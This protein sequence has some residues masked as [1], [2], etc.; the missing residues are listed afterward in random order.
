MTSY[1]IAYI[2]LGSNLNN[3][4]AQID[5]AVLALRTS[6]AVMDVRCSSY[7]SS[8]AIGPGEQPDY[9][10]AAIR[11]K[12]HLSPQALLTQ[13][14]LIENTHGRQRDVRW[15]ARTLD[16]DLLLY[17]DTEINETDLQVPHPEITNRN[18]VLYP[19]FDLNPEMVLPTGD[20]LREIINSTPMKDLHRI[21]PEAPVMG[22]PQQRV[23][24]YNEPLL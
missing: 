20:S 13:L 17:N 19:L 10:N 21:E 4:Q 14:Q 5:R 8:K 2:G 6:T 3:P 22:K 12:T 15:G 9:I 24:A 1:S 7:Y 23:P 16:L 11:C 18:F